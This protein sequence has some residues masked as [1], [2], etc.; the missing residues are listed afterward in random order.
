M[1]SKTF[2][3]ISIFQ[4]VVDNNSDFGV[5][6]KWAQVLIPHLKT[7]GELLELCEAKFFYI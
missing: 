3:K 5:R 7:L 6:E 1:L 2:L 4:N